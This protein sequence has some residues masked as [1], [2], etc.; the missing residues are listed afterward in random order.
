M[1]NPL[2]EDV[3]ER[4]N[5]LGAQG[6]ELATIDAGVW[7]FK[8][9]RANEAKEPLRALIEETVPIVEEASATA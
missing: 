7:I 5:S 4:A 2:G 8:R 6:W 9:P 3:E 1:G